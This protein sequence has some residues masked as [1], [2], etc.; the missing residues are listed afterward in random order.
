MGTILAVA[1]ALDMRISIS[2]RWRA[3]DL[4]R[5]LNGAH[6]QLHESV[7]GW[8]KTDLPDWILV[9]EVSFAV[10]AERGIIDILAWQPT[11]RALLLIELK[12]DIVDVNE[13]IG[14]MDIRRRLARTIARSVVGTPSR[15]RRGSSWRA[16]GRTKPGWRHIARCCATPSRSMGGRCGAG[17]ETRLLP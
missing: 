1:K 17:C 16:D 5:L 4:D 6:S 3:G 7:A 9:P 15:F 10:F 11:L 13:L 14:T 12:T 2:A 8:F